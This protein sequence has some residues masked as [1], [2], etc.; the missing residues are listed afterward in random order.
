MCIRDSALVK[1]ARDL[2]RGFEEVL[3]AALLVEVD[4]EQTLT[5]VSYTHLLRA[6]P[7]RAQDE[8]VHHAR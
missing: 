8:Y 2:A 6:L 4:A 7:L 3:V 5:P 1:D